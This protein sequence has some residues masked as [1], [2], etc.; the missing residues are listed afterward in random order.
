MTAVTSYDATNYLPHPRVNVANSVSLVSIA[1]GVMNWP[2]GADRGIVTQAILWALSTNQPQYTTADFPSI[3]L[4]QGFVQPVEASTAL[5]DQGAR[6][7][8][9]AIINA[10]GTY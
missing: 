6:D 5:W 2:T 9:R 10:A 4:A 8:M 3:A 7:R 1:Q